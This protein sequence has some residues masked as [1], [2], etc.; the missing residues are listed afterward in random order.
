MNIVLDVGN[1]R[2][3]WRNADE[4]SSHAVTSM[5]VLSKQWQALPAV[6]SVAIYGCNVRGPQATEEIDTIARQV[7]S[8][9]VRWLSS[10][11]QAAGVRNGYA[12]PAQLGVDRWAAIVAANARHPGRACIVIDAGT[13]ITVD[14][15][16]E[17]GQH[18]GGVIM[19]GL[20]MLFEGLGRAAQLQNMAA[21]QRE[22]LLQR[23]QALADSTEK[24]IVSGVIFSMRGGV[25]CVIEQQCRQINAKIQTIPIFVTGGDAQMLNFKSLQ[26]QWLPDLVLDGVTLLSNIEFSGSGRSSCSGSSEAVR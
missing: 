6:E 10:Q 19:P 17:S 18:R 22:H 21:D 5:E 25:R 3:K 16:D 20:T 11:S 13:A 12:L 26:M 7:F 15:I 14:A 23:C 1:S 9:E 24:A 2:I 4:S 8:S